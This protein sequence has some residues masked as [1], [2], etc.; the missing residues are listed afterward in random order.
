MD[1]E[2][3]RR[4]ARQARDAL[5]PMERAAA[6]RRRAAAVAASDAWA[7]ADAVL[8]Y[9]PMGSEASPAALV[10]AALAAGK[11][12]ALP[13]CVVGRRLEWR[14]VGPGW[15]GGLGRPPFGMAEPDPG[16][17]GVLD[18]PAALAG[19]ASVLALCPGLAFDAEGRRLG[20]GGGYYDRFLSAA[21]ACGGPG[22]FAAA[23]MAHGCQVLEARVLALVEGPWDEPVDAV[24]LDGSI[25]RCAHTPST[26]ERL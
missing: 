7:A 20:Y 9:V 21:R 13:R 26:E 12:V 24:A 17:W 14:V 18:V 22:T 25:M 15:R 2:T 11:A 8:A 4:R 10:D 1:K 16:R 6:D 5:D 3:L 19:G 23:G